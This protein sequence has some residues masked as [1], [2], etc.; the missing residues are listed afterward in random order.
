MNTKDL[1]LGKEAVDKGDIAALKRIIAKVPEGDLVSASHLVTLFG[2]ASAAEN[3]SAAHACFSAYMHSKVPNKYAAIHVKSIL[4]KLGDPKSC[5][6]ARDFLAITIYQDW[7]DTDLPCRSG[8]IVDFAMHLDTAPLKVFL[9]IIQT[10]GVDGNPQKYPLMQRVLASALKVPIEFRKWYDTNWRLRAATCLCDAG[11]SF[12]EKFPVLLPGFVQPRPVSGV[13]LSVIC[14]L[15]GVFKLFFFRSDS[16]TRELVLRDAEHTLHTGYFV[17]MGRNFAD[18]IVFSRAP[19]DIDLVCWMVMAGLRIEARVV[20]KWKEYSLQMLAF[21]NR[22]LP[23]KD[24]EQDIALE[25]QRCSKLGILLEMLEFI[26]TPW[27]FKLHSQFWDDG[28]RAIFAALCCFKRL[29]RIGIV[30]IPPEIAL[31]IFEN[32]T[33]R[34]FAGLCL[35]EPTSE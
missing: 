3:A 28:R 15:P 20:S 17:C 9:G 22:Q 16:E 8:S 2:Y 27:S 18:Q 24:L 31:L 21:L 19:P 5:P 34:D 4:R 13:A 35:E 26:D 30:H 14:G 32:L 11:H 10:F 1:L 25:E 12:L 33:C 6:F 29:S 23:D 7:I